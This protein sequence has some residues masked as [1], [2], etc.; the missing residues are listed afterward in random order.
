MWTMTQKGP[1]LRDDQWPQIRKAKAAGKTA[2]SYF[3]SLVKILHKRL[4]E[5]ETARAL[6]ELMVENARKYLLPGF[7]SFGIDGK[8]PYC[9]ASYFKLTTGEII[10]YDVEIEKLSP[11]EVIYRLRPPCIWFPDLDIPPSFCRALGAFEREAVR[12]V[13]PDLEVQVV[14][15]MTEGDSCCELVFKRKGN[16]RG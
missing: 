9:L 13:N 8:D 11:N 12:L 10:G 3:G 1:V 2:W 4:G 16:Q 7:K 15:L 5:E 6:E 14:K